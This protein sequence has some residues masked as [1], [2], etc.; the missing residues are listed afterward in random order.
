MSDHGP[1]YRIRLAD[2]ERDAHVP[3]EDQVCE[4]SEAPAESPVSPDKLNR[5]KLLGVVGDGRW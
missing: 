5:M 3:V 1:D 2:L 4:Q